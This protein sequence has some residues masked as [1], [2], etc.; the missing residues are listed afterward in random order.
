M[1]GRQVADAARVSRPDL[2]ILFITG[3]AENAVIGN[4]YLGAGMEA[5]TK[6]FETAAP[7]NQ[8]RELLEG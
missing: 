7:G 6:P 2:K 3:F 4:G 5:M 1:N 8:I